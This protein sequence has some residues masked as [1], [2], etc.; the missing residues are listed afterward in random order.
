MRFTVDH[1]IPEVL[2]GGSDPA[3][4]CLACWDCNLAKGQRVAAT[5]PV[6]AQLVLLFHPRQQ[7]WRDH[8]EWVETGLNIAGKTANGR[9]TVDALGLNRE[10]LVQAR[11]L[12]IEVG[13]HPPDL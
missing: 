7:V 3:N 8:F 1:I 13:W 12:W 11:R 9:A 5:D 4:L 10:A 6:S 2:G